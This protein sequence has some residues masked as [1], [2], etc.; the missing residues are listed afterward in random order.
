MLDILLVGVEAQLMLVDQAHAVVE[1]HERNL[2]VRIVPCVVSRAGVHALEAVEQEAF[3]DGEAPERILGF[4][5]GDRILPLLCKSPP[6]MLET[7]S[8]SSSSSPPSNPCLSKIF[9][10]LVHPDSIGLSLK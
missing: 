1:L 3:D 7:A 8:F 10:T 9:V 6:T 5:F 2:E 4:E